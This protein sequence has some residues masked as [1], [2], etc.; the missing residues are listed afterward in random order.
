M[1]YLITTK[2]VKLVVILI[3]TISYKHVLYYNKFILEFSDEKAKVSENSS[4]TNVGHFL[5]IMT[6]GPG[7]AHGR[8][9]KRYR[10]RNE[11]QSDVQVS[12]ALLQWFFLSIS[13]KP[14][15]A[16]RRSDRVVVALQLVFSSPFQASIHAWHVQSYMGVGQLLG[17]GVG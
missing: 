5:F 6:L 7:H 9:A 2:N 12:G 4:N 3:S 17:G 10:S 15:S 1:F 16:D 8:I 11:Y 14:P 13:I